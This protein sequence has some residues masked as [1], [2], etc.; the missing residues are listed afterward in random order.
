[1]I[2]ESAIDADLGRVSNY[3]CLDCADEYIA[4]RYDRN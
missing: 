4:E 1:M 2:R 3:L